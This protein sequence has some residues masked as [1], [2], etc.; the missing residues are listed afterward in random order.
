MD[1][2][3]LTTNAKNLPRQFSAW[4]I[5]L[6]GLLTAWWLGLEQAEQIRYLQM[7]PWELSADKYPLLLIVI[8]LALRAWP[9]GSTLPPAGDGEDNPAP[10]EPPAAPPTP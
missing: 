9:Q 8:G 5:A 1:T 3:A 7:L 6:S 2:K 4:F 10:A